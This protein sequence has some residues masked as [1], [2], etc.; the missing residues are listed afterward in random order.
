MAPCPIDSLPP[1]PAISSPRPL[2]PS[3]PRVAT[4]SASATARSPGR[5][6]FRLAGE[7]STTATGM[8][9]ASQRAASS[10]TSRPPALANNSNS[11]SRRNACGVCAAHRPAR[12]TVRAIRPA[13]T[14]FSVSATGT[15][16]IAAPTSR[17]AA[18][19]ASKSAAGAS[20]RAPSWTTTTPV[21]G[22]AANPAATESCRRSAADRHPARFRP[23]A[24]RQQRLGFGQRVGARHDRHVGDRGGRLQRVE[25]PGQQRPTGQR[26]QRLGRRPEARPLAAGDDDRRRAAGLDQ[27]VTHDGSRAEPALGRRERH[28]PPSGDPKRLLRQPPP[29]PRRLA[30]KAEKAENRERHRPR[31]RPSRGGS[32]PASSTPAPAERRRP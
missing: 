9:S 30:E 12:S 4:S 25:R 7:P 14:S 29:K 16:A 28:D 10:V 17:A 24:A 5:V 13:S 3:T 31:R 32:R 20:G 23:A 19:Q 26:E 22:A 18:T 2:D 21:A 11:S 27:S 1:R 6:T 15:A 8:P